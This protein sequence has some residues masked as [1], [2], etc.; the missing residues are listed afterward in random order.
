MLS[1]DFYGYV[2]YVDG[3]FLVSFVV[4]AGEL[5]GSSGELTKERLLNTKLIPEGSF[6][7]FA[8]Q[9]NQ[10]DVVRSLLS[11]GAD[12]NICSA[13]DAVTNESI[14]QIYIEELLRATANSEYVV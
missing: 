2:R 3:G 13:F 7:L 6:L 8:T 10:V 9:L 4:F 12:P 1:V 11:S 5:D 14:R